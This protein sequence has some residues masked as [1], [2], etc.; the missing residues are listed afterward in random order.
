MNAVTA[1]LSMGSNMGDK[2][3]NLRRAILELEKSSEIQSIRRSKWY[4]TAPVGKTDQ[5]WFLN[6][7][8][9]VRTTLKPI[10]LLRLILGIESR[11]G[12][13]RQERWG[14]R[15]IDIDILLYDQLMIK[16]EE[17]VIPHPRM[18]ERAF[19][20]VPLAELVPALIFPDGSKLANHLN[21]LEISKIDILPLN[22]IDG[23]I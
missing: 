20:L 4:L 11:M 12:R 14:P 17:L 13:T 2:E 3:G 5:A 10:Q 7:V 6:G 15:N 21:N 23:R 1:F 9:E 16:E 18:L 19:V 8:V 22:G